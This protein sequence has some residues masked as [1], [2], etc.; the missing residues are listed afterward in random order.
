MSADRS[1]SGRSCPVHPRCRGA[2]VDQIDDPQSAEGDQHADAPTADEVGRKVHA[3]DHASEP[4][5]ECDNREEQVAN[6]LG[7]RPL[8]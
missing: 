8:P 5:Q 4:D 6:A 3:V 1:P 2:V 7:V